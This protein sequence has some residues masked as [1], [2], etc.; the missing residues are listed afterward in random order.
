MA[1]LDNNKQKF[2]YTIMNV[3]WSDSFCLLH[4][5]D[6]CV[7]SST[8][9]FTFYFPQLHYTTSEAVTHRV[10]SSPIF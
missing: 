5:F 4:P 1:W 2:F 8:T 7:A 10:S 9:K 6:A 3:P